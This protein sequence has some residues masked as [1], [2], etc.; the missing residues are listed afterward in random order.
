MADTGNNPNDR[1]ADRNQTTDSSDLATAKD[2]FKKVLKVQ[3]ASIIQAQEDRCQVIKDRHANHKLFLA[4]H[5]DNANCISRLEDLLLA[6]N[7]KNKGRSTQ[8][9]A[10]CP[11]VRASSVAA[12]SETTPLEAHVAV[13][14]VDAA[15]R[16]HA[17]WDTYFND[18]GCF[19][20]LDPAA[21]AALADLDEQL[22][23]NKIARAEQ[24]DLAD[25]IA[26]Q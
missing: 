3:N 18:K 17:C 4:A 5:Q 26:G 20:N 2:W 1:S 14:I 25:E 21:V 15:I 16:E 9:P 8:A 10:G 24:A 13:L 23:A 7:I 12:I 19:P 11:P 22:L 6:M